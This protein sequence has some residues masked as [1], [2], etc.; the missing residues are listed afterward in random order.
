MP[1]DNFPSQT[2]KRGDLDLPRIISK[3][4]CSCQTMK[5]AGACQT[6]TWSLGKNV[7]MLKYQVQTKSTNKSQVQTKSFTFQC[8]KTAR[9]VRTKVPAPIKL[10]M[11]WRKVLKKESNISLSSASDGDKPSFCLTRSRDK[12]ENIGAISFKAL[13]TASYAARE[14]SASIYY[15]KSSQSTEIN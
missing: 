13:P 10:L 4:S 1:K 12:R 6:S 15:R 8:N 9:R 7:S 5:S 14:I 3:H 2:T 11:F